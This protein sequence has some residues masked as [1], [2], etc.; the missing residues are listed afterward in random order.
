MNH[1]HHF[2]QPEAVAFDFGG[3]LADFISHEDMLQLSSIAQ[4][5]LKIFEQAWYA[6]RPN[7]DSGAAGVDAYW[8]AVLDKCQS[9]VGRT[10]AIAML[11]E[12]DMLGFS[13]MRAHMLRWAE[14]L[15]HA[16][17][18]T[19]VLSNMSEASY[20]ELVRDRIWTRHFDHFV[21]SGLLGVNKP[22]PKIFAHAVDIANIQ[23][24][25]LL[26]IDDMETNVRA[27]AEAGLQVHRYVDGRLLQQDIAQRFPSLPPLPG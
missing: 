8:H 6:H 1:S 23:A 16:G 27:A 26:F 10:R 25:Q 19:L 2:P 15:H 3:V 14:A 11:Q 20:D 24:D 5:P 13:H 12:I 17:V 7:L 18:T 21:I 9:S 4:V 22:D